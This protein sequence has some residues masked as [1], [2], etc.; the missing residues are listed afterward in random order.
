MT[1]RPQL[2]NFALALFAAAVA[3]TS[4]DYFF[5]QPQTNSVACAKSTTNVVVSSTSD[6][7]KTI[8]ID[9]GGDVN[10]V[11]SKSILNDEQWNQIKQKTCPNKMPNS[12][13]WPILFQQA[14][15]ELGFDVETIPHTPKDELF[16]KKFFTF[17]NGGVGYT[18]LDGEHHLVYLKVWKSANDNIRK[19]MEII[20]RK[21]SN[22]WNYDIKMSDMMGESQP[23]YSEL[24]SPIPLSKRNE[25]CV[26]TAVRDPVEH[27][28][29]AYNEIEFRSTESFRSVHGVRADANDKKQRYYERYENGTDSRFERYVAEFVWGASTAKV[30]PSLP[31]SNIFHSFSQS[32]VLWRLKEQ[33]DIMGVNAPQLTAYIPTLFNISATFPNLIATN[34]P[35]FE[36]EFNRPFPKQFDH[37]SQKDEFGFYAAAKRVWGK[38]ES[39]SRALCAL[40]LMDYACFDLIPIPELCQNVFSDSGFM[41][42]LLHQTI[43]STSTESQNTSQ[44]ACEFCEEGIPYPDLVDDQVEHTCGSIKLLALKEDNGTPPC[45][46]IQKEQSFCCPSHL[47]FDGDHS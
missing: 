20:V 8:S 21:K 28:L 30:Y 36:E 38:Q 37:E 14:R 4:K 1:A 47:K 39:T 34:C 27:F 5:P 11:S 17:S 22:L 19:N 10:T 16:T 15:M 42:R 44:Q 13:I 3:V 7:N 24:W 29:S 33:R 9:N 32:G 18:S 43:D 41:D 23:D 45:E 46:I 25:T 12:S 35:G 6:D 40:H 2:S 26:V 31:F